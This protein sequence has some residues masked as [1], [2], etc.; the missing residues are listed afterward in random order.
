MN[1]DIKP[2][3]QSA[4]YIPID[5]QIDTT[6][7]ETSKK[8]NAINKWKE[9]SI[10]FIL[11]FLAVSLGFIADNIRENITEK[12]IAHQ[13]L[14]DF[15]DDLIQHEQLYSYHIINIPERKTLYD[16]IVSVFYTKNEN[17]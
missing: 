17:T 15:R 6:S 7:V 9:Y 2:N 1:E 4:D 10:Q 12:K 3:D 11:I 13:N 8:P 14:V 16:S 5:N